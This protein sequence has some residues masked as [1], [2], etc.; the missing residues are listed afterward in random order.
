[1]S[2]V[3][4]LFPKLGTQ[5]LSEDVLALVLVACVAILSRADPDQ[6][7]RWIWVVLG[8]LLSFFSL[9]KVSLGVG[10]AAALIVTVACLPRGRRRVL[11]DLLLGAVPTFCL[12]WFGTGN[13]FGN[14]VV[15][16]KGSAAVIGGYSSAM[17]IGDPTRFFAYG[18]VALVVV[19]VGA[20]AVAQVSGLSRR[21]TIGIGL[22]TVV[23]LWM[24]FK[25]GFV[26]AG[27]GHELIFFAAAPLIL[28]AFAPK[29]WSWVVAPGVLALTGVFLIA[30]NSIPSYTPRPDLAV[31]NLFDE[32]ATLASPGR[33]AAIIEQSR[34]SLHATY[35]I[36]NQMVAL[37][38]NRTVDISPWEQTVA[39]VYPQ[40]R[41]DPL[42]VIQDYSAYTPSL[43][44]LDV[45]YLASSDAPRFILR[46]PGQAIDGRDPTFEPPATQLAIEC[47]YHQV[48]GNGSWQLLERGSDR[49]GPLR[50]IGT[51]TTGFRRWV[52]V[53]TAPAGDAIVARFQLSLGLSY[54]LEDLL[55]KPENVNV[56]YNGS[57]QNSWRF[58]TA[59]APDL[60]LL[61]APSTSG[62]YKGFSPVRLTSFRFTIDR[63]YPTTTGV[64]V[65]FYEVRV[66][67]VAGGNGE[68]LP[69]LSTK[70][71]LPVSGTAES[72][73]VPLDATTKAALGVSKVEFEL[74]GASG[75][76]EVIATGQSSL[77]GWLARWNT[78][79][80][81]NGTYTLQSVVYDASGRSSQSNSITVT[82]SN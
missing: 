25:E 69:P 58:V 10:I 5:A 49:C 15:F 22:A 80:V 21:S 57:P 75:H 65:R 16:A 20:V 59:T 67:P 71:V 81:V 30:T 23:T 60:H 40:I 46:Q 52:Q 42:P 24:L 63:G 77:V 44:Q 33:T 35:D 39:W 53:P 47:R 28:A 1:M 32:A 29:R 82:V 41:F 13:G 6:A 56:Q 64:T 55:F 79:T 8:G 66:A 11:G 34:R 73:T 51:V 54:K 18:L 72:G 62:Y 78:T 37:M 50:P 48:A 4:S 36:P 3:R 38:R 17:S 43:D 76:P 45:N 68:L 14:M 61:Q 7:P 19:V 74:T 27:V 26:R 31:R 70:V 9:V 2:S 12:G